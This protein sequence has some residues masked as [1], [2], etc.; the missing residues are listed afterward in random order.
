MRNLND[1]MVCPW[2]GRPGRLPASAPLGSGH[3]QLRHPALRATNSPATSR[4][5]PC[6]AIRRRYVEMV[7]RLG[8]PGISPSGGLVARRLL[9]SAGSLGSVP[10]PQ[11]YYST[12]RI[13][14]TH[15]A[16]LRCLRTGG[17]PV[18]PAVRSRGRRVSPA[19]G[20]ELVTRCSRRGIAEKMEGPPRFLGDLRERALFSDPGGTTSARPSRR[21]DA[22]FHHL[23]N[24]G[25]HDDDDFGAQWHGPLT[26]CL[27][28]AARVAPAPRKT[29]SRL[30][31]SSTGRG[32]LPARSQRKVSAIASPFPKLFLAHA[33]LVSTSPLTFPTRRKSL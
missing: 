12:L 14:T 28:F 27:R 31:A 19:R 29:R 22:A 20:L 23:N 11:R 26:R 1:R 24:V 7:S 2:S 30:L 10:P 16:A 21:R 33:N 13:P 3:A 25:S 5:R 32:W 15:P 18:T 17:I 4:P 9:P 6:V 8:V